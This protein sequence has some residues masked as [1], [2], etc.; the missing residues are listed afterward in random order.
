MFCEWRPPRAGASQ[1][2][3]ALTPAYAGEPSIT[4]QLVDRCRPARTQSGK[5]ER[6]RR[7]GAVKPP[8]LSTNPNFGARRSSR[9]RTGVLWFDNSIA[10]ARYS[11]RSPTS[12]RRSQRARN[13]SRW[14]LAWLGPGPER[15]RRTA[16]ATS[17]P[18]NW[19]NTGMEP[20]N[21]VTLVGLIG[22][23]V[24]YM[25]SRLDQ[26]SVRARLK[27]DMELLEKAPSG[28][29]ARASLEALVDRESDRLNRPW[30]TARHRLVPSG[31]GVL[32]T[33]SVLF[34]LSY[35]VRVVAL[36]NFYQSLNTYVLNDGGGGYQL[37]NAGSWLVG[38]TY[39]L[40]T[41]G[42]AVGVLGIAAVVLGILVQLVQR[43][44]TGHRLVETPISHDGQ[45]SAQQ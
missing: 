33:G 45:A 24:G 20:V 42:A 13:R 30:A 28:T 31:L 43:R 7:D 38:T 5:G 3:E 41:L 39:A 11:R 32:T 18:S 22:S 26:R 17:A 29:A 19:Q 25:F 23:A 1:G 14:G 36:D 2:E 8:G 34:L 35:G 12:T 16:H 9:V 10:A 27:R 6:R 15:T 4:T 37:N 44:V 40:Q 21:V